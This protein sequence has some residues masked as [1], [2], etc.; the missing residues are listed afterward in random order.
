MLITQEKHCAEHLACSTHNVSTAVLAVVVGV[1]IV[2]G[3]T[4][5]MWFGTAESLLRVS[6]VSFTEQNW[7]S[8]CVNT[9]FFN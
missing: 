5:S 8:D 6:A 1:G 3:N 4:N 9:V 7:V 2:Q